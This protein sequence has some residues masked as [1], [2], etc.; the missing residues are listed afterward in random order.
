MSTPDHTNPSTPSGAEAPTTDAA[1]FAA[2]I[3]AEGALLGLDPGE[4]RIGVAVCDQGRMIASPLDT[5]ARVRFM[6]DAQRVFGWFDQRR[7]VGLVIGLPLN[8]D[9]SAGPAA[10]SARAFARNLFKVRA[11]PILM[12]DE[13]M[14]TAAVTRAMIA[15]DATRAKRAQAVDKLAASYML[16]GAIDALHRHLRP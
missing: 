16:Q 7:C 6:D 11:C 8:M 15:A 9:G 10:Q 1:T 14:S 3:G 2:M 4:K 12:W 13:R 5:I